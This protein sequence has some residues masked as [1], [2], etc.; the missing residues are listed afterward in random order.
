[1]PTFESCSLNGGVGTIETKTKQSCESISTPHP[2]HINSIL[3]MQP[4]RAKSWNFEMGDL[5]RHLFIFTFCAISALLCIFHIL[6]NLHFFAP[7][8]H[9]INSLIDIDVQLLVIF[10]F[11]A[12]F[13][14]CA[15]CSFYQRPDWHRCSFDHL[16]I[17]CIF[18]TFC[19]HCAFCAVCVFI[20]TWVCIYEFL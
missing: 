7:F 4:D 10:V 9:F 19:V 20:N 11:V 2:V 5:W 18:C 8:I 17:V 16:R 1:M 15:V 14:I 13:A 12:F 6:Q 3:I